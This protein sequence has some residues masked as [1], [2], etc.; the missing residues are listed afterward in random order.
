MPTWT[1]PITWE[2]GLPTAAQ[3]N[4][5]IKENTLY[6]KTPNGGFFN[7]DEIVD[8]TT[9]ATDWEDVD[10]TE[11][12]FTQT[13]T[14]TGGDVFVGATINVFNGVNQRVY[15][16]ITMDGV[17]LVG[18]DGLYVYQSATGLDIMDVS[19]MYPVEA[20]DAGEHVFALQW[21]VSAGTARIVA[22]NETGT[23][24]QVNV[25]FWA[26]EVS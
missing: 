18:D 15:F 21:K 6:L 22:S 10:S 2:P 24:D 16:D 14:T 25:Q 3:L 5:Q 13:I 26:E 9:T 23:Y 17:R 7:S 20:P 11:G 1:P 12:T 8:Y 19:F 4:E